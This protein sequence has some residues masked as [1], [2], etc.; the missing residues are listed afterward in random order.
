MSLASIPRLSILGAALLI[1]HGAHADA[2]QA[3]TLAQAIELGLQ[4]NPAIEA[5]EAAIG[6]AEAGIGQARAGYLPD[7]QLAESWQ[8][9]D[10]PVFAFGTLLNQGRFTASDFDLDT[11]NHPDPVDNFQSRFSVEQVLFDSLRTKRAMRAAH[12]SADIAAEQQRANESEVVLGV[13]RTYFGAVVAAE[14]LRVATESVRTAEADL[15]RAQ[16][17][18]DAGMTTEA[19][20]LAVRV[21]RSSLEQERIRAEVDVDVALAALDDALGMP[22]DQRYELSTTLDE[23]D[24][25]VQAVEEYELRSASAP[26]S[27]QADLARE[28]AHA[29]TGV[30]QSSLWP[31]LVAQGVYQADG[32]EFTSR[33][34]GNWLA[35]VALVWSIWNGSENRARVAAARS[36]EARADALRRRTAS[37]IGLQVRR[38]HAALESAARRV[39]VASQTVAAAE[40]S[41]RIIQNRY[42]AGLTTVTELIRSQTALLATRMQHLLALY[43]KRVAAAALEHAAGGLTPSSPSVQ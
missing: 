32:E 13:V 35:G 8:R 18:L 40:E 2:P 6:E 24:L 39:D 15:T 19:D 5:G 43:E 7:L 22:L 37:A 16:N 21:H 38:A 29:R 10:V 9:S 26:E 30:A 17:L 25:A 27:R 41:Q 42:E 14:S 12:L 31:R 11:L 3:L 20:V 34:G 28:Q 1:G 4:S 33:N 23:T 36:A